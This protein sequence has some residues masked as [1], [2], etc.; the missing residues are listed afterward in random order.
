MKDTLIEILMWI[1]ILIMT[2]AMAWGILKVAGFIY[3]IAAGMYHLLDKLIDK[4]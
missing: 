3:D 4:L 2:T 1:G